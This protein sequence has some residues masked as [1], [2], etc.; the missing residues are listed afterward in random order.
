MI[1][2]YI[3]CYMHLYTQ[4][5]ILNKA[6]DLISDIFVVLSLLVPFSQ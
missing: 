5:R 6:G 4:P 2:S 3:T 1:F